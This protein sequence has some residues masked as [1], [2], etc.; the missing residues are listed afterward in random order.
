MVAKDG[1]PFMALGT[2]GNPPQ[3]VTE[4]LVN[5]LEFGL[6]PREAVD[7]PRFW[8]DNKRN[9]RIE[10]RISEDLREDIKAAGLKLTELTDYNWH[11]GSIQVVW[12]DSD[13]DK[14]FGISDPRRLGQADGY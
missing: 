8:A 10:S 5:L 1:K 12:F 4:V 9:I 13:E 14:Y 6:S 11:V 7:A 2:P 3:P